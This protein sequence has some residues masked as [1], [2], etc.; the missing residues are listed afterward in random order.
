[1]L[2]RKATEADLDT[3]CSLYESVSAY[4]CSKGITQWQWG[5]YP[6]RALVKDDIEAGRMYCLQAEERIIAAVGISEE[7]IQ[8]HS[9]INWLFGVRPGYVH[10]LAVLPSL[11]RKGYGKCALEAA[12][13]T[14]AITRTALRAQQGCHEKNLRFGQHS[15]F[16]K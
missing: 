9:E 3:L 7:P 6:S 16:W 11:W 12:A 15:L 5:A 14:L 2:L 1:M 8:S 4:L 13:R 10:R